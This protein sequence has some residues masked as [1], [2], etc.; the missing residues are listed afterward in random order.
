MK[1]Y[2]DNIE[3]LTEENENFRKVL[4]TGKESQLVLMSLNP[5]EDIG[6]EVHA[7]NDQFFRFEAGEGKVIIDG[8]EYTVGDGDAVV[9]PKGASHNVINTSDINKLKFYTI[10]SPAHH[11]D[12]IV[13]ATKEEALQN[14]AEFDGE[15]TEK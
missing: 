14:E 4:Y 13:R 6:E 2:K 7:E 1:G 3:K 15:T 11:K 8:N 10:Y 12:G 9:V 5:K